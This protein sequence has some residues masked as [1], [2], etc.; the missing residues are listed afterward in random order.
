MIRH[1]AN[2][3]HNGWFTWTLLDKHFYLLD[4][5]RDRYDYHRC[6]TLF[7]SL[8]AS[9]GGDRSGRAGRALRCYAQHIHQRADGCLVLQPHDRANHILDMLLRKPSRSI[10]SEFGLYLRPRK[11]VFWRT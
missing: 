5:T 8:T 3:A 6:A 1:D 9:A 2:V 7:H 4:L 10:G 11:L